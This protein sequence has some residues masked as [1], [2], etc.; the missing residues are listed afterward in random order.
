[1]SSFEKRIV[2]AILTRIRDRRKG[3][4]LAA[5]EPHRALVVVAKTKL[6]EAA[7]SDFGAVRELKRRWGLIPDSFENWKRLW[8]DNPALK[9]CPHTLPIGWVL[10]ADG[11]VVGYLGNIASLYYYGDRKLT[12]VTGHGF[13]VESAYRAVSLSLMAAFFRQKSV[14]LYLT[15][16]AIPVVGKIAQVFKSSPLPQPHYEHVLF[17]VLQARPFAQH[18]MGRLQLRPTLSAVGGMLA[19]LAIGAD[20]SLRRRWPRHHSTSLEVK[21]IGVAEIG[22]DFQALWAA[23]IKETLQLLADRAP[24][25]LRWHFETPGDEGT[26]RVLC[27]YAGEELLG[28]AVVSSDP[29]ETHGYR[30]SLISDIMA[31]KD[32]SE[33]LSALCVAAYRHAKHV[34]SHTLEVLGFPQSVRSVCS[35][36]SPYVRK[37]PSCPF[38]YKAADAGLHKTLADAAFWYAS[39]FDGDTT[40]MPLLT[41]PRVQH[42]SI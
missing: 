20:K 3:P 22:D 36:W 5:G 27:C 29:A 32:D 4:S 42:D 35:Q 18:V 11:R 28:Y 30:R 33:I 2:D 38:Y 39:P 13:V 7:F 15:T 17:W 40:L 24:A 31:K 10:E 14:D 37:Y 19:S 26:T 6:R 12:A 21:E 1:M 9:S 34:G 8:Q 41:E 23:K 25:T 16:T